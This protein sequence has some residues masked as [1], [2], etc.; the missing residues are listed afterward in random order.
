M[1]LTRGVA[2]G[3]RDGTVTAVF[4]RWDAPRVRP[5]GTQRTQ[6]GVVRFVSVRPVDPAALTEQDATGAGMASLAQLHKANAR[7]RGEQLYRIGVTFDRP[8]E[9]VALRDTPPNEAD[10]ASITAILDRMDRGRRTGPWTRQMLALIAAHPAV[11]APDLA[12]SLGRETQPFKID[13][14][15]LKELGLTHSLEIGY[16]LSARGRAY[17]EL[18]GAGGVD[19]GGVDSG[20]VDPGGVDSGGVDP[21]GVDPGGVDPGGADPGGADPAGA[22]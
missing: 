2:E 6:A 14:R 7:G 17:L 11:R 12:A 1:L 18:S 21:G 5:G 19:S 8:D 20:G 9:R 10:V 3:I 16:E 22:G 15:K 4:R 13:V